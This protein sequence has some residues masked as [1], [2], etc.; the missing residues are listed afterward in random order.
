MK[1]LEL[2]LFQEL[3][4][5]QGPSTVTLTGMGQ[6]DDENRGIIT[7]TCAGQEGTE[8]PGGVTV[9]GTM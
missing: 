6:E 2:L 1:H 8:T 3:T 7:V 5:E 4:R 9:P